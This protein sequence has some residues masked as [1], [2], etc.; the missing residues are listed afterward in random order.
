MSPSPQPHPLLGVSTVVRRD[1]MVLL[2]ERAKPPYEKIWAFPGGAVEFG[3]SLAVAA[4]REVLEET[5]IVVEIGAPIDHAEI[6]PSPESATVGGHYVLVVFDGRPVGGDLA[7]GDDAGDARWFA[8]EDLRSL[9]MTRDTRRIL[10][11]LGML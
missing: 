5:G 2:I 6:L 4:A 1:G 10:A 3:E 9:P 8:P 11:S 7:A